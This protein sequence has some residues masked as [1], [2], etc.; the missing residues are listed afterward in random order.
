MSIESFLYH[1]KCLKICFGPEVFQNKKQ[2]QYFDAYDQNFDK[3]TT[4]LNFIKED[5]VVKSNLKPSLNSLNVDGQNDAHLLSFRMQEQNLRRLKRWN[6]QSPAVHS[7]PMDRSLL[8]QCPTIG[9]WATS[10]TTLRRR[11]TSSSGSAS[12]ISNRDKKLNFLRITIIFLKF[13]HCLK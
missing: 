8:T 2:C 12:K 10:S 3:I 5:F 6:S 9:P 1:E 4:I 11:T 7:T 13:K